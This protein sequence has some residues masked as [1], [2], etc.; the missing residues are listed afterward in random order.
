[1]LVVE[2]CYHHAGNSRI[3]LG[4]SVLVHNV[5]A[6]D[7]L[8]PVIQTMREDARYKV[9]IAAIDKKFPGDSQYKRGDEVV[10][11]FNKWNID[12]VRLYAYAD[13]EAELMIRKLA[14]DIVFRQSPWN[15]DIK[16]IY[17]VR[18][19]SF[20]KLC[21]IP[22]YGIQLEDVMSKDSDVYF[23]EDQ[24]LHRLAWRVFLD[25]ASSKLY[26]ERNGL[27]GENVVLCDSPKYRYIQDKLLKLQSSVNKNRKVIVWAPHH[28]DNSSWLGFGTFK[29]VYQRMLNLAKEANDIEFVSRPHPAFKNGYPATGAVTQAAMDDF[30]E[31]WNALPNTSINTE[32]D[33]VDLFNE[34]GLLITDGMSFIPSYLLTSKPI[35]WFENKD[36]VDLNSAGNEIFNAAYKV[37]ADDE[38]AVNH[39]QDFIEKLFNGWDPK[40]E[41]R[42]KMVKKWLVTSDED[43]AKLIV[44]SICRDIGRSHTDLTAGI[45]VRH[46][47]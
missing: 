5:S 8:L 18:N 12:C 43:P 1:M 40:Y 7:V 46:P 47:E 28:S 25:K 34:S 44:D 20:T 42:Q 10:N 6:L 32:G 39:V 2:N 27:L 21:Y 37:A 23:N 31:Q 17:S 38:Q 19:L 15:G 9:I 22:Y 13:D 36:H 26:R 33:Y 4:V 29:Y 45:E 11:F 35:I 41:M 24:L 14:P 3:L 30:Y 16:A